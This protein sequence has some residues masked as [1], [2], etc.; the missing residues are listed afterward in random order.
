LLDKY[1][2]GIGDRFALA[3]DFQLEAFRRAKDKGIEI[4]PVW[5]KSYREHKTVG[6]TQDS[7]R[8]EADSSVKAL[9]WNGNYLVDADHITFDTVDNF[10][11]FSDFFTIDVAQ[12]I[13]QE[14]TSSDTEAFLSQ[15][16]GHIGHLRIPGIPEVFEISES[17]LLEMGHLYLSAAKEASRIYE[18]IAASKD[19]SFVVEVSMDEVSAPQTPVEL[20]FILTFLADFQVPVNT[21]APKFTGRFNKGIDYRGDLSIFEQ[22]FEQDILVI[23]ECVEK[24]GLPKDLKLSV[25]TGS[26]KF[27]LYPIIN[28]L[29][30]KH[31]CG[32]HL[33]TAGTTWLEELIG[34]AESEGSGLEMAKS[35]YEV[36][37]E[38]FDE[39][40]IPYQTV[41]EVE[42]PKLP[43]WE[44]VSKWTGQQ[45]VD[46]LRHDQKNSSYNPH[47]R[48]LLHTA[49]KLA[50]EKGDS[51]LSELKKNKSVIGK[52][53][54]DNI[55]ERHI[56][57]LF[58]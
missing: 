19:R 22:E 58:L 12:Q 3:G 7:V 43:A 54:T 33:K 16:R 18:K 36:A 25:H 44:N 56:K 48:Q 10:I 53:I 37:V 24:F 41:I 26:D 28:R 15:Y 6:S 14:L 57:P 20:F 46:A 11:P 27:S 5:N 50:A 38:R 13:G 52:N 29:I 45:F 35:I 47:F 4:T 2:F 40:T 55:F 30:K 49:Y 51:F 21:I 23:K 39:L 32:L 42:K 34:L 1:S 17:R 31:N 8:R 9:N